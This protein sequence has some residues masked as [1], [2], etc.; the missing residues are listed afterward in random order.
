MTAGM[1][2]TYS[3]LQLEGVWNQNDI[4]GKHLTNRVENLVLL[5]INKVEES[6]L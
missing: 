3:A 5:S 2:G 6:K 1:T 4:T